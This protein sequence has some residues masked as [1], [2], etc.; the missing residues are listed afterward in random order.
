MKILSRHVAVTAAS[1]FVIVC[2]LLVAR[3]TAHK[4]DD[5]YSYD[6]SY[7]YK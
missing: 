1:I 7:D 4:G 5:A 6:A 2:I 3:S